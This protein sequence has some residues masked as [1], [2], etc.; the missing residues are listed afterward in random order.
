LFSFGFNIYEGLPPKANE[1]RINSKNKFKIY[2]TE[3]IPDWDKTVFHFTGKNAKQFYD[4]L[5][6]MVIEVKIL[7]G[8]TLARFDLA[9]LR[10]HKKTDKISVSEFLFMCFEKIKITHRKVIMEK[11]K[12]GLIERIAHR[13]SNRYY[14]IYEDTQ[15]KNFLKFEYEL[16]SKALVGYQN[17]IFLN[18]LQDFES[19]LSFEFINQFAKLL[20]MQYS[21]MD[22]LVYKVRPFRQRPK[23]LPQKVLNT[24]YITT[25]NFETARKR[26]NFW[27]L[28]QFLDFV[29]ELSYETGYLGSTQYRMVTFPVRDFLIYKNE[30]MNYHQMKKILQFFD[31]LQANSLIK[32]FTQNYYRSLVTIPEVRV[33]PGKQKRWTATVWIAEELFYYAYPFLFPDFIRQ[34]V[35]KHQ[36]EVQFHVIQIFTSVNL[37]KTFFIKDYFKNYPSALNN[38]QK[39][40]I[41]NYFIQLIQKLKEYD[42][43]ESN[44]KILQNGN[45]FK[46]R[47]LTSKNINEGFVI[48][49]KL[50]I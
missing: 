35:T 4:L 21:Y 22:W 43:I 16:K 28:L 14:R 26:R 17:L 27:N 34:K 41:K 2:V 7:Q 9:Y 33:F 11:N 23:K 47:E 37:E 45:S 49:E 24:D 40:K 18:Q 38:S 1:K 48:Y 36:F 10:Y 30:S 29:Q 13:K 42:L 31:E 12:S 46:T 20:P 25:R 3:N 8:A 39:T 6:G 15:N 19:R 44:F 5:K 50:N 32:F